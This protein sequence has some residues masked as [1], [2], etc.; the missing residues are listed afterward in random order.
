MSKTIKKF[1]VIYL[2]KKDII[3]LLLNWLRNCNAKLTNKHT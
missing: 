2:L 3:D 1:V